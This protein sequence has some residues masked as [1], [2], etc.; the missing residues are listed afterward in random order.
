MVN[1][2]D[3]LDEDDILEVATEDEEDEDNQLSVVV[4]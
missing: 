2:M 4:E 3:V 1:F